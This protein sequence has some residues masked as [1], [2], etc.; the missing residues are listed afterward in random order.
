MM[1][2]LALWQRVLH[3]AGQLAI[4][5]GAVWSLYMRFKVRI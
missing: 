2:G 4:L 1:P 3:Y 5:V